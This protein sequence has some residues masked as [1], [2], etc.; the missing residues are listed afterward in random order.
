MLPEPM[1]FVTLGN[2]DIR[3]LLSMRTCIDL[4]AE[5]LVALENGQMT[6]SLRSRYGAPGAN[7]VLVW[8]P[9]HRNA[10]R[11]QFGMKLLCV[12][13]GNPARGLDAHQGAVVLLDGVTGELR[14]LMNA[15]AITA[16]RTAAVS[17]VATRALAREDAQD[18]AI[19]G[20]G[21]Q[22]H[23]HI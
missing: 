5:V 21:H 16:I 18:L 4:M 12:V 8:M 15:S 10:P 7:G 22:A 2:A 17:G 19:V 23:P 14:A 3:R 13:P 6:Q 11:P 9:A 20:A 1:A